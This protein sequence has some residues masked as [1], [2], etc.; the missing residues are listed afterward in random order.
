MN[1]VPPSCM[2]NF[3]LFY[4]WLIYTVSQ[5]VWTFGSDSLPYNV[6]GVNLLDSDFL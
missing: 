3:L 1:K 6:H 4:Y 2:N 5:I